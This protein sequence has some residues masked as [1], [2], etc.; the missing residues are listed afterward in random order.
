[1][2]V[3]SLAAQQR[4]QILLRD[5]ALARQ[6]DNVYSGLWQSLSHRLN[7]LLADMQT[8]EAAANAAG[9]T[10]N[11][12]LW[13]KQIR[14]LDALL[15]SVGLDVQAFAQAAQT[16]IDLQLRPI[17]HLGVQDALALLNESLGNHIGIA[18]GRPSSLA[19]EKLAQRGYLF[20]GMSEDAIQAVRKRLLAGL[21]LG[22]GPRSIGASIQLGLKDVTRNRAQAIARTETISAY[23]DANLATYRAN[24]DVVKEWEWDCTEDERLCPLCKPM[25]HQRFPLSQD[26]EAKHP[27]D[28]C[29]PIPVTYGYDEILARLAA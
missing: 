1:M 11:A 7:K 9:I 10:F 21:A 3:S 27:N 14:G 6:I 20:K 12:M 29:T 19:L 25:D 8:A 28:R 23:R 24:D 13:I 26:F 15:S 17:W 4:A 22:E 2:S 18:F 5:Q 16:Y